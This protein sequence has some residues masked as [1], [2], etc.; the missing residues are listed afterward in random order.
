VRERFQQGKIMQNRT[1]MRLLI[2]V[3]VL[4]VFAVPVLAHEHREVGEYSITFGW[5]VEPAYA[6]QLNGPEVS[7]SLH[8]AHDE[9]FPEDVEVSLSAEISFGDQV[10]LLALE[11]AF[12]ETGHYV[13][14]VIPTLPGDY[15]FRVFGT[16][17]DT[18]VD[19]V[20]T[21]ADGEFSSIEPSSDILFPAVPSDTEALIAALEARIAALEEQ[22]AAM[23]EG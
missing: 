10:M 15:S 9:A 21:S 8:D 22:I 1:I 4:L 20:F 13:A 23:Q 7:L 5:R 14:N 3:V 2:F 19:E 6:G 18:E 12:G 17:G 11:P 16:I